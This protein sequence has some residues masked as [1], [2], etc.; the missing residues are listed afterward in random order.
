MADTVYDAARAEAFA[1][2]MLDMLNGGALMVMTSVGHR[3]GLFD[4]LAGARRG[5]EPRARRRGRAQR[6]L[7]PRV[8]RRDGDGTHRRARPGDGPL[9]ASGRARRLAHA[10]GLSG[11]PRRRGAVDPDALDRRGRHRRVLREGR[12]RAVR[13]LRAI[14]RG[15]GGGERADGPLGAVLAHPSA[16]SRRWPSGSR[17][18][19]RCSTSAAAA[20]RAVLLGERFPAA[21]FLGYDLSADAIAFASAA[22]ERARPRERALRAARPEHLR[23][24]RRA[25]GVRLRD[26]LR[27]GARPGAGRSRC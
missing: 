27:R 6:A 22:G 20:A 26:D 2:R 4:A 5:D 8:A 14:P 25:R 15:H 11:Q 7:R 17:T 3:T 13:A 24:R 23:R 10:R 18:A 12:R 9:L 16:R 21:T 1:G 19:R